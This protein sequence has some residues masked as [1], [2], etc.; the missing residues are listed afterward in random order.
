MFP[1]WAE[2]PCFNSA[3][4]GDRTA[5]YKGTLEHEYLE[6]LINNISDNF[7][8]PIDK[9]SKEAVNWAYNVIMEISENILHTEQKVSACLEDLQDYDGTADVIFFDD[10][11][12]VIV[13]YKS[14]QI[15]D[16]FPQLMGY[17]LGV[18]QKHS[19][20]NA[21]LVIIY[22]HKQKVDKKL[23]TYEEC[24]S[25]VT[26]IINNRKTK[27]YRKVCG[28]C[29]WC[30]H[31][32]SCPERIDKAL[33]LAE[34]KSIEKFNI[35]MDITKL[36]DDL[37]GELATITYGLDKFNEGVQKELRKRMKDGAIVGGWKMYSRK[38]NAYIPNNKLCFEALYASL[39][40]EI[41]NTVKFSITKLEEAVNNLPDPLKQ[42]AISEL[43]RVSGNGEPT[44]CLKKVD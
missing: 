40:E 37:L 2:C 24:M 28:H 26:R 3:T 14:G 22:G 4:D 43:D 32:M 16:S 31:Q 20:T 17:A 21:L 18:M 6:Y 8:K 42:E 30:E 39:G 19:K 29:S 7:N 12:P 10:G 27:A 9:D 38:G 44:M 35:N 33:E 13:D 15:R 36:P 5:M 41:F 23:V 1:A 11:L 25:L 34:P